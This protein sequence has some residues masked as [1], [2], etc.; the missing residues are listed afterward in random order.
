[1]LSA[2]IFLSVTESSLFPK[3][4]LWRGFCTASAAFIIHCVNTV[5]VTVCFIMTFIT[6]QYRSRSNETSTCKYYLTGKTYHSIEENRIALK[7]L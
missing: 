5:F 6:S 2:V 1:M 3:S 4:H 7:L